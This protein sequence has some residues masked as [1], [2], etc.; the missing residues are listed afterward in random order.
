MRI[1]TKAGETKWI[2]NK[3]VLITWKGRPATLNFLF[4]VTERQLAA[5]AL[6]KSEAQKRTILNAYYGPDS[7]H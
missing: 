1:F 2:E 5:D 4:D 3:G 7:L 6:L